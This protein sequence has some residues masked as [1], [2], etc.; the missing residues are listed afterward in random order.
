MKK[1]IPTKAS[2]KVDKQI[3]VLHIEL[4][5][6]WALIIFAAFLARLV[7]E[8]WEAIKIAISVVK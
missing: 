2:I 5:H 7:P 8:F 6:K 1:F 4:Q 3:I